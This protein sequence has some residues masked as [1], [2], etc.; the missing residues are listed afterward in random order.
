[1]QQSTSEANLFF[2][3]IDLSLYDIVPRHYLPSLQIKFNCV[4]MSLSG[5]VPAYTGFGTD[6]FIGT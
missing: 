4:L 6:R 3:P 5:M 2:I 1:M